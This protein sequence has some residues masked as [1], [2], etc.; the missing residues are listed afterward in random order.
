MSAQYPEQVSIEAKLIARAMKDEAFRTQLLN[1]PEAAKAAVELE[2]GQ[3][4]PQTAQIRVVQESD[5]VAYI[6]LP[7]MAAESEQLSETELE[8]VAAGGLTLRVDCTFFSLCIT[9]SKCL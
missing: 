4:L 5:D 7:A 6:I 1:N 8:A 9:T 2:L 3:K